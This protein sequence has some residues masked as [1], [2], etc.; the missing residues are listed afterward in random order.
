M[1][2]RDLNL[3]RLELLY[4][5]GVVSKLKSERAATMRSERASNKGVTN[6]CLLKY[7]SY[8][9]TQLRLRVSAARRLGALR[10]WGARAW[11]G[12]PGALGH[13]RRRAVPE[14]RADDDCSRDVPSRVPVQPVSFRHF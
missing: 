11:L 9:F 14:L 12:A 6:P 4:T 10:A 7:C 5:I 8:A 13:A 3:R 2:E 1:T